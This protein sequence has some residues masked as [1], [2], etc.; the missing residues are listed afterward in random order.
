MEASRA[1]DAGAPHVTGR[2]TDPIT[3]QGAR[4]AAYTYTVKSV[5]NAGLALYT[6]EGEQRRIKTVG[7]LIESQIRATGSFLPV[8]LRSPLCIYRLG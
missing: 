2:R 5:K 1:I 4:K 3:C 7:T 6:G 8:S